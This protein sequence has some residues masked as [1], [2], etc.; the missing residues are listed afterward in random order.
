MIELIFKGTPYERGFQQG[1]MLARDIRE[2][3]GH[4]RHELGDQAILTV[5][6]KTIAFLN[7]HFPK[8]NEEIRGISD[9]AKWN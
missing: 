1:Q 5:T 8:I 2:S 4:F 7:D 9:E 3:I 6:D